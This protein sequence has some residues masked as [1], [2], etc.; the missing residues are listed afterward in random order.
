MSGHNALFELGANQQGT[1]MEGSA[2]LVKTGNP[3]ISD[4]GFGKGALCIRTDCTGAVGNSSTALWVNV[5]TAGAPD[6]K[7]VYLVTV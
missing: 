1:T 2:I 6:W 4:T 5:G 3:G 7:T